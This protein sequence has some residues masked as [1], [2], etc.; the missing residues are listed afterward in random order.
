MDWKLTD[1]DLGDLLNLEKEYTYLCSDGSKTT[2]VDCHPVAQAARKKLLE[3]L[4][5]HWANEH[6][7]YRD[8]GMTQYIIPGDIIEELIKAHGLIRG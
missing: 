1:E 8:G 2:T 4:E 3:Y 6:L 7:P 5:G